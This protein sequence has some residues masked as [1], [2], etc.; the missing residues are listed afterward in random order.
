MFALIAAF[1]YD[2]WH[3]LYMMYSN[4]P[5]RLQQVNTF[6]AYEIK[7]ADRIRS[8]EDVF[9]LQDGGLAIF[10]CDPGRERHNTVMVSLLP[11]DPRVPPVTQH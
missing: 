9:L 10:G 11:S 1:V 2:R 4:A 8:C 5:S 3:I 6:S 7:Y